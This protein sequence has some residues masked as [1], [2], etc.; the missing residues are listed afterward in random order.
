VRNEITDKIAARIRESSEPL[1][2]ETIAG[3]FLKLSITSGPAVNLLVRNMLSKDSR[4]KEG[5][6]G[7]WSCP[8]KASSLTPEVVVCGLEIPSNA[9]KAPWLW[10]LWATLREKQEGYLSHQG[11]NWSDQ[12]ATILDWFSKY[13]VATDRRG[14]LIRW[15]GAQERIHAISESDPLV[16]DLTAWRQ[17]LKPGTPASPPGRSL[18]DTAPNRA[19][20]SSQRESRN[21]TEQISGADE[22]IG[23]TLLAPSLSLIDSLVEAAPDHRLNSWTDIAAVPQLK[24]TQAAADLWDHEWDF[25]QLDISSLPEVPGVYRFFDREGEMLYVG[26]SINLR[27]RVGDYFRPL[28]ASSSRREQFLRSIFRFEVEPTGTELEALI[29]ESTQIRQSRPKWNVMINLGAE[30]KSYAIGEEELLFL[31]RRTES[32]ILS[33]FTLSGPRAASGSIT[34]SSDPD[35]LLSSFR[36]FFVEGSGGDDLTELAG[37]E[38]ILVRRWLRGA[39]ENVIL[40]PLSHFT[41]YEALAKAVAVAASEI[42]DSPSSSEREIISQ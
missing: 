24:Q 5:S 26:K 33:M 1:S 8:N 37:P 9:T 31:V 23:A 28:G 25:T 27:R 18:H 22:Q 30:E 32:S 21:S 3:D 11:S 40:F 13:P 6:S 17:I 19:P 34:G 39:R 42:G 10:R 14:S 2:A 41:T 35:R 20:A 4:F 38:R 7:L 12:L 15:L 29:L 36:Q 16:I